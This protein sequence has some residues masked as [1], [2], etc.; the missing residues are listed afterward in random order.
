[1]SA[2]AITLATFQT[3]Q[4]FLSDP[5]SKICGVQVDGRP[6]ASAGQ[7]YYAVWWGKASARRDGTVVSVVD[8]DHSVNITITLRPEAVPDDRRGKAVT[9]PN[10]LFDLAEALAAPPGQVVTGGGL[11]GRFPGAETAT[12]TGVIQGNYNLMN[13][14]NGLIPGT[15]Q[16]AEL[17]STVATVNG[18]TEPLWLID[19]GPLVER[20]ATWVR[21]KTGE[22]GNVYSLDVRFGF[23]RRLQAGIE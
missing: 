2:R 4:A 1:M 23:A 5:E 22:G 18:F 8:L 12:S 15:I 14:A 19:Y 6:P 9:D 7:I 16:Y 21:G 13:L 17:N 3:L 11:G 20:P 10:H